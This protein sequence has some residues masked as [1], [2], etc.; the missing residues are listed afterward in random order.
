[1]PTSRC[2]E[3][4]SAS[5]SQT[6]TKMHDGVSALTKFSELKLDHRF[7][8]ILDRQVCTPTF[9][10]FR[11]I[12]PP[13]SPTPSKLREGVSLLSSFLEF[14]FERKFGCPFDEQACMQTFVTFQN[15]FTPF[16]PNLRTTAQRSFTYD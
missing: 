10:K 14:K 1:M 7:G 9:V 8:C 6:L 11:A 4:F 2:Y 12:L 3:L 15:I 16:N 5:L 13:L